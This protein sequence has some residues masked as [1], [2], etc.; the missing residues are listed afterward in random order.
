MLDWKVEPAPA[1]L[2]KGI[3]VSMKNFEA[4]SQEKKN[5]S[6]ARFPWRLQRLVLI[7]GSGRGPLTGQPAMG[8]A[9][10]VQRI[11][12]SAEVAQFARLEATEHGQLL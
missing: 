4:P 12:P 11:H 9:L 10:S 1:A 7:G 6:P 2:E 3:R 5:I 8:I